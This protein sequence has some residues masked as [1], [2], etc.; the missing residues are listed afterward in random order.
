MYR[1]KAGDKVS[2]KGGSIFTKTCCLL[3]ILSKDSK[4]A[5]VRL[6]CFGFNNFNVLLLHVLLLFVILFITLPLYHTYYGCNVHY[7]WTL[8]KKKK[9]IPRYW[10]HSLCCA[11]YALVTQSYSIRYWGSDPAVLAGLWYCNNPYFPE[12]FDEFLSVLEL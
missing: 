4:R 9:A 8:I 10:K 12:R 7:D 3:A 5:L 11:L 1:G 2:E 6:K